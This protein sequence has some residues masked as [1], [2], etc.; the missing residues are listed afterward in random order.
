MILTG[1]NLV[2]GILIGSLMNDNSVRRLLG[3]T[4]YK[5][6]EKQLMVDKTS[7]N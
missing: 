7:Y 5:I 2:L 3:K 4:D 6:D 1:F